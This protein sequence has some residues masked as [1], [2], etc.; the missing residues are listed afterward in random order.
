MIIYI[1]IFQNGM[2]GVVHSAHTD[3][4]KAKDLVKKLNG[5]GIRYGTYELHK[6]EINK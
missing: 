6:G 3:K 5:S 4:Q 2:E 1:I